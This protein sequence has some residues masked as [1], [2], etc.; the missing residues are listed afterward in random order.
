MHTLEVSIQQLITNGII[1]YSEA[2]EFLTEG[3]Y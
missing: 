2:K 1:N 3:D